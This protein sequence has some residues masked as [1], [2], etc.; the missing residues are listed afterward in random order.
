MMAAI[1][2]IVN[3]TIIAGS[4]IELRRGLE[5]PGHKIQLAVHSKP[6]RNHLLQ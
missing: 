6:A 3:A 4:R 5:K 2:E 1:T